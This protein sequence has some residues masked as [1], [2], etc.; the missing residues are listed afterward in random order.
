MSITHT[1]ASEPRYRCHRCSQ[2]GR[3]TDVTVRALG[4][5]HDEYWCQVCGEET[6][7]EDC[8]Q[9]ITILPDIRRVQ[10]A[11]E[12]AGAAFREFAAR[13]LAN[14]IALDAFLR[15]QKSPPPLRGRHGAEYH[16]R[17]RSRSRSR[18]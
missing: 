9:V 2:P 18:R 15:A 3:W 13:V 16:R 11:L 1:P 10:I 17:T 12:K 7:L 4:D 14:P 6:P 8:E 5:D